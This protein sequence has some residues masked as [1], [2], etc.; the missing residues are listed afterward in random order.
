MTTVSLKLVGN[1][2]DILIHINKPNIEIFDIFNYLMEKGLSFNEISKI[3]FVHKGKN[4]TN[5]K[6]EK[7]SGTEDDPLVLHIFTNIGYIKDEIIKCIYSSENEHFESSK[8]ELMTTDDSDDSEEVSE[9]VS[10]EEMN[11]NNLK[12]IE[13]FSDKD[14]T[15]LLNIFF[16]KPELINKLSSYII[17]GNISFEIK[18]INKD[19]FKYQNEYKD[20][21]ELLNKINIYIDNEIEG[22]S[23]LQHFEGNLN[24]T[25]RYI[26]NKFT[27]EVSNS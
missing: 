10:Q 17:N 1:T 7:Y 14:F 18:E 25:M 2:H 15:Y 11:K 12:I 27:T 21:L 13:L 9:E 3:M 26:I 4:I 24:L 6:H 5:D 16:N 23:I 20:L 22:M 19:D 8:N